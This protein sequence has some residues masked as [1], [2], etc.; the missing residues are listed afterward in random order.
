MKKTML[1]A[2]AFACAMG[3]VI[4]IAACGDDD[5]TPTGP[6]NGLPVGVAATLA[7]PPGNFTVTP[8]GR[9]F[10]SLHQNYAPPRPLIEVDG[11]G[12]EL[13]FPRP[14]Q[15]PL[16]ALVAVLGVRSDTAGVLW[17]LDNGNRGKVT[18]KIVAY[19]T[20]NGRVARTI[21]G[22]AQEIGRRMVSRKSGRIINISSIAGLR[23]INQLAVY[24]MSKAG[25]IQMTRAMA[26]E[27][28]RHGINVNAICPGY[29][30]TE[31]NSDYWKSEG[32]QKLLSML[33]RKRVGQSQDLDGVLLLLASGASAFI[34]GAVISADDGFSVA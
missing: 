23:A 25:L 2:G 13:A 10:F 1:R 16:P 5:D 20:R 32:G 8:D 26:L 24:G 6:A 21:Q 28:G 17:I 34:N 14:G 22:W 15:E 4:Q 12:N 30:E 29:I 19:D 33:P 31:I 3:A 18:P 9:L 27:W 7:L 11:Q